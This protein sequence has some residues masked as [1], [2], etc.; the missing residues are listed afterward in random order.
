MDF[1]QLFFHTGERAL[2]THEFAAN[3]LLG[4]FVDVIHFRRRHCRLDQ[5][6][7]KKILVAATA[8]AGLR[9]TVSLTLCLFWFAPDRKKIP[10]QRSLATKQT[11]N[12]RVSRRLLRYT[13]VIFQTL[14]DSYLLGIM[15]TKLETTWSLSLVATKLSTPF[16]HLLLLLS[17]SPHFTL[18]Q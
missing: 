10:Y 14:S 16:L 3:G 15:L 4:N 6:R 1:P 2:Y 13:I 9:I 7:I 5:E 18:L 17:Q 12:I 8:T 11:S